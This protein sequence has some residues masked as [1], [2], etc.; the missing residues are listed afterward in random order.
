MT[1]PHTERALID[2]DSSRALKYKGGAGCEVDMQAKLARFPPED[3]LLLSQTSGKIW[4]INRELSKMLLS[5]Y[6]G[7][8]LA[9]PTSI[10]I[11]QCPATRY[12]WS[13]EIGPSWP[14]LF[15]LEKHR[16]FILTSSISKRTHVS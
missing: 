6:V 11:A 5:Y 12:D 7:R 3:H 16:G 9:V 10:Y 1:S 14:G 4:G 2:V 8:A 13:Q 15:F